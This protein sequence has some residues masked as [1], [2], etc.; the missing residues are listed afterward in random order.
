[1]AWGKNISAN[2]YLVVSL[3]TLSVVV[4]TAQRRVIAVAKY[5]RRM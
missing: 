3:M 5:S 2:I 1:M 4:K